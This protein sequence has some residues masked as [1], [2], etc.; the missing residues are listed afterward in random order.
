MIAGWRVHLARLALLACFG[1]AVGAR[2]ANLFD[3][4]NPL[5]LGSDRRAAK[6]G[7]AVTVLVVESSSASNTAD[8]S[9]SA[10]AN[11]NAKFGSSW[12]QTQ[13]MT[14]GVGDDY[15][16]KGRIQRSGKLLA[17]I[18]TTIKDVLPNGDFVIAGSQTINMNG[19][20][21]SIAL[22]GRIR[23]MDIGD[24]NTILSSRLADAKIDYVGDGFLTDRS[25]P[26]LI[27]RIL[28]WLGL[29]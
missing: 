21:T 12:G 4:N 13:Q 10:G 6:V 2:A 5:S 19:E 25:K 8:T 7:D 29:W 11:I 9:T 20:K 18:S 23:P 26:G 16:G 28:G 24:S 14:L 27:P 22:E 3:A 15:G 17:Q 1:L